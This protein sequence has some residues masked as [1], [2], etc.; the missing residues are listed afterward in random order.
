MLIF[1]E[2]DSVFCE[3]NRK[4]DLITYYAKGINFSQNCEEH[5]MKSQ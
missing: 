4:S 1:T 5:G 3:K 2:L